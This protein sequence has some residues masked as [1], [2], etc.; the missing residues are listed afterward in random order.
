V[1][2]SPAA[3]LFHRPPASYAIT[4]RAVDAALA[5]SANPLLQTARNIPTGA[6]VL[7]IG[8]GNG[9]LGRIVQALDPSVT[10]DGVEPSEAGASQAGEHYR[11]FHTGYAED[12]LREHPD[13]HYDVIV[14]ND[15]IEHLPDPV[16]FLR[17]LREVVGPTARFL[18][19][20]PNVAYVG[21]RLHLLA[22]RFDYVDSGILERTHLRFFS[23]RTLLEVFRQSGLHARR[24]VYLQRRVRETE[25]AGGAG[26]IS[27]FL[28]PWVARDPMA[29]TYQFL[30]LLEQRPVQT[31]E[32]FTG[33]RD[34]FLRMVLKP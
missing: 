29:F 8:A 11:T 22:G 7:D 18:L 27:A 13:H 25:F 23:R 33:R 3:A 4:K 17:E 34:R 6:V 21:M 30:F 14:L 32:V 5:D 2:E 26:R 28:L 20:T 12:F 16:A 24:A 9:L 31:E 19:S 1:P 15:V 10:I